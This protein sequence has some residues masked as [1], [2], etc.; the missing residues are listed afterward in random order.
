LIFCENNIKK[1]TK[2]LLDNYIFEKIIYIWIAKVLNDIDLNDWD[3]VIPNTFLNWKNGDSIFVSDYVWLN[4]NLKKFWLMMNGVCLTSLVYPIDDSEFWVEMYGDIIDN[5]VYFF[6]DILSQKWFLEDSV[7]L[8][9]VDEND[10]F[11]S[12]LKES[13]IILD[14]FI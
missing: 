6:A 7:I 2:Y 13:L 10:T 5:E 3:V 9:I 11:D 1:A 12:D 4:Y 8:K 14:F